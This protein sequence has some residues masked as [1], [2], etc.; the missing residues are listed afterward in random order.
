MEAP[1]PVSALMHAG[2]VNAGGYLLIRM[3]PVVTLAPVAMLTVAGAG[4]IYG[5]LCG[6]GDAVTVQ[7][8]TFP[9][10]VHDRPDGIHDSA[11]WTRH[12][13]AAMLH[14]IAHSLY[15]AHAFLSSGGVMEQR[16]A[17]GGVKLEPQNRSASWVLLGVAAMISVAAS[18]R[19]DGQLWY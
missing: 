19:R 6:A 11:V 8:E 7:R 2:I 17:T 12:F 5:D 15:K 18:W 9:G 10:M 1:T 3:A 13:S 4:S 16:A 14:I